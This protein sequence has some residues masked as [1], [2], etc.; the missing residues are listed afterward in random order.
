MSETTS[1]CPQCQGELLLQQHNPQAALGAVLFGVGLLLACVIVGVP[2]L[3]AGLIMM[4]S[5][6]RN[7]HCR[8]CGRVFPA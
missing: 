8:N 4:M 1:I 3:I 5:D 2:L 7:W 6:K